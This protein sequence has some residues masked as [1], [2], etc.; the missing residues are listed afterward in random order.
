MVNSFYF[1]EW[2]QM[3]RQR[4][5]PVVTELNLIEQWLDANPNERLLYPF[6]IVD[7]LGVDDKIKSIVGI[8][9]ILNECEYLDQYYC[10][11]SDNGNG[12]SLEEKYKELEDIPPERT[13]EVDFVGI[14]LIRD[15]REAEEVEMDN[16]NF[17][18]MIARIITFLII[19]FSVIAFVIFV[20]MKELS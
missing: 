15:V 10:T 19:I 17:S 13:R 20:A 2:L 1:R 18:D 11:R 5:E 14:F 8:Y 7:S 16:H 6:D 9:F 4:F 12:F 3:N